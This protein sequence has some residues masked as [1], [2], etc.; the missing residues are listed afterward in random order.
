MI[1]VNRNEK[2][3]K[4]SIAMA[5]GGTRP[6]A[7]RKKGKVG[8]A[9]REMAEMAKEHAETAL[10]TLVEV[11]SGDCAASARVSAATA[12]LDRAYGKPP[13]ALEHSAPDN[14][15]ERWWQEVM[16]T[17]EVIR[18]VRYGNLCAMGLARGKEVQTD[19]SIRTQID[20]MT[21][22][23]ETEDSKAAF[24]K[25]PQGNLAKA[26]AHQNSKS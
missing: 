20:G 22:Y 14:S 5:R 16:A 8:Q 13:Q 21:Y 6:G 2:K 23:F 1:R 25:D 11:A 18:P 10:L 17:A 15:L 12:I 4:E 7:G 9:K 24:M 26:R 19:C 3:S